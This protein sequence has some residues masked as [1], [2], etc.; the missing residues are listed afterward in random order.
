MR[1]LINLPLTVTMS[2]SIIVIVALIAFFMISWLVIKKADPT[3]PS[4]GF[5]FFLEFI[6]TSLFD[7]TKNAIGD[8]GIK[9]MPFIVTATSY[10]AIANLL[11]LIGLT[12]PTTDINITVAI[13]ILTL[14]YIMAS[15]IVSKG[16]IKYLKDTYIGDIKGIV[17]ILLVPISIIGELSKI[18]SLSF[19]LFG[20]IVSG[21]MIIT[22]L[23]Q[24]MI[25]LFNTL[26]PL[27]AIGTIIMNLSVMPFI[28]A[29]FDVFAGLM[30]TFIFAT[31]TTMFI[32]SAIEHQG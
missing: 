6:Y 30:Q 11:G 31:L 26:P 8:K 27:G 4:K 28:N 17:L 29:Y 14:T 22:L 21:A 12:P 25:W 18:I 13:T 16:F 1:D 32:R 5:M 20:N 7:F 23:M 19:R 9:F 10:L 15:G 24:F 3:N 2:S